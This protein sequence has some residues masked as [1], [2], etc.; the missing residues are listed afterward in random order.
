MEQPNSFIPT[1]LLDIISY[2]KQENV[3]LSATFSDGRINASINE[4]EIIKTLQKQFA[5][6]VPRARHWYDFAVETNSGFY[7]VNI[8]VTDTTH[9]DN[10]NCKLGIYYALTGMLPDFPNEINWLKFFEKLKKNLAKQTDKDY[11]FLIVNKQDTSDVFVNGLKMLQKL[12]SNGNNLP[13]QCKW[14]IN[15]D[16]EHRNFK[17][18]EEFVLTTFGESIKLRSDIYFNFKRLFPD[19]V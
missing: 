4:D 15:R 6:K 11:F 7:P 17:Q 18:A 9:A 1:D 12:Q 19:Y 14:D 10:L 3:Y 5:I 13:F 16:C 8:K 2:L